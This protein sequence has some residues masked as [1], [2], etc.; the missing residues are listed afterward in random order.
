MADR[1]MNG[2][3]LGLMDRICPS[4]VK[5][6]CWYQFQRLA[7]SLMVINGWYGNYCWRGFNR[8]YGY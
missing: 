8:Y 1:E 5:N 3:I 6:T 4:R 2:W 7:V